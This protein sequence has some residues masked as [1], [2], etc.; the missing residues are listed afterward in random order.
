MAA[1]KRKIAYFGDKEGLGVLEGELYNGSIQ[2]DDELFKR[3]EELEI[4]IKITDGASKLLE[5]GDIIRGEVSS[6]GS[7]ESRRKRVYGT[8]NGYQLVELLGSE[9]KSRISLIISLPTVPL[10][11]RNLEI[12]FR[13]IPIL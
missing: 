9:T 5:I 1:D 12:W 8:T 10:V 6:K 3:A 4:A 2:T 13:L 7:F 11:F